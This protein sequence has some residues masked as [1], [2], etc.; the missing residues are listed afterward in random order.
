ML[1]LAI[2]ASRLLKKKTRGKT[3]TV[4][5]GSSM[6]FELCYFCYCAFTFW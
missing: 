4:C 3:E 5:G 2:V 1:R 6:I